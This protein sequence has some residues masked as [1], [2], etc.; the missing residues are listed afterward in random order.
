MVKD[1]Y[2]F[3]SGYFKDDLS[4]FDNYM[5]SEYDDADDDEDDVFYYGLSREEAKSMLFET[6]TSL[7]FVITSVQEKN[8]D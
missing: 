2:Y 6:D 4:E 7:E 3:I 8:H 5:V 1:K